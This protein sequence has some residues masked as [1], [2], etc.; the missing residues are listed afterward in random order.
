MRASPAAAATTRALLR[1]ARLRF[2]RPH[3]GAH[4]NGGSSKSLNVGCSEVVDA[5]GG[6]WSG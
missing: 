1:L 6:C 5:A 2:R 3:R 4:Q